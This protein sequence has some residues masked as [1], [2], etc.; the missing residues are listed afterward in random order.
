LHCRDRL[1][2]VPNARCDQRSGEPITKWITREGMVKL[3]HPNAPRFNPSELGSDQRL[4]FVDNAW[5]SRPV[6]ERLK[7]GH[8]R[9]RVSL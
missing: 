2:R 4:S 5:L 8:S 6:N 3:A 9:H 7:V 1:H